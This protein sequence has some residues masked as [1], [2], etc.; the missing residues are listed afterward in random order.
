M[1]IRDVVTAIPTELGC[2]YDAHYKVL[3]PMEGKVVYIHPRK[4]FY[5]LEFEFSLG[6]NVNKV[7][8]A[9]EFPAEERG[10][11]YA[12]DCSDECEGRR[13][14]NRYNRK[15]LHNSGGAIR[16]KSFGH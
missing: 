12:N 10:K 9:F 6:A 7:R 13:R 16:E 15:H 4:R 3:K 1:R 8:E 11:Q 2:E 14:K 5:V